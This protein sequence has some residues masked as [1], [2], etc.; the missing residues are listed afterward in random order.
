MVEEEVTADSL[1]SVMVE[2][3]RT[4]GA[5]AGTS[6]VT[7]ISHSNSHSINSSNNNHSPDS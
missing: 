2:V 7:S 6:E 3:S 1:R 5:S 4:T